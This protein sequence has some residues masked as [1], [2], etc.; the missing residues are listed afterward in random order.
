MLEF[1]Q[2]DSNCVTV[3]LT[4]SPSRKR[5]FLLAAEFR[6]SISVIISPF[7]PGETKQTSRNLN[8]PPP[9]NLHHR[10]LIAAPPRLTNTYRSPNGPIANPSQALNSRF[11]A[12]Q[13]EWHNLSLARAYVADTGFCRKCLLPQVAQLNEQ[14]CDFLLLFSARC[15]MQMTVSRSMIP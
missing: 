3:R 7:L 5:T 10:S 12:L 11:V 8:L 9:N 6:G 2:K 14:V 13:P 1:Q 4:R 15:A